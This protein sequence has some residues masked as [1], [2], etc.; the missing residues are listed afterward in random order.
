MNVK[1]IIYWFSKITL[2]DEI[3][4]FIYWVTS[5]CGIFFV[6][7][8][9]SNSVLTAVITILYIATAAFV[10]FFVIKKINKFFNKKTK[11]IL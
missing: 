9:S 6:I 3:I 5:I 1:N 7:K 11:D 2:M 10:Y 4:G 8:I